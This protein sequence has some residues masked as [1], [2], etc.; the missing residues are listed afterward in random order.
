[1]TFVSHLGGDSNQYITGTSLL[2]GHERW[3]AL[4]FSRMFLSPVNLSRVSMGRKCC[5]T[6]GQRLY[7]RLAKIRL[8][9]G[10]PEAKNLV[11]VSSVKADRTQP[12]LWQVPSGPLQKGPKAVVS[13][14][15]GSYEGL[16]GR[17][18]S[19]RAE[20]AENTPR[21]TPSASRITH[22]QPQGCFHR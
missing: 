10:Q 19:A 18:W 1:M 8:A 21:I 9:Q 5:S 13:T 4:F 6:L 12:R 16:Q 3:A 2:G 20:Q 14:L 15:R 22:S 17:A 7:L 11:L